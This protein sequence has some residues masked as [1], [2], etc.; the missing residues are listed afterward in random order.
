VNPKTSAISRSTPKTAIASWSRSAIGF[1]DGACPVDA[2]SLHGSGIAEDAAPSAAVDDA[3]RFEL[4][5][6]EGASAPTVVAT[7]PGWRLEDSVSLP[8]QG[9]PDPICLNPPCRS[10]QLEPSGQMRIVF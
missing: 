5:A 10:D 8:P 6:P 9:D 4:T 3:C 1:L 7:G 2:V